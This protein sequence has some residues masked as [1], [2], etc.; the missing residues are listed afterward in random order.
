MVRGR[1]RC[2]MCDMKRRFFCKT[3]VWYHGQRARPTLNRLLFNQKTRSLEA[4]LTE[5]EVTAVVIDTVVVVIDIVV[6][7]V[8]DIAVCCH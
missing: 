5:D 3:G 6:V 4:D 7:V 2:N 8:I 1:W